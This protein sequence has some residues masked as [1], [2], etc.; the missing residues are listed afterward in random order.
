M[1]FGLVESSVYGYNFMKRLNE[2]KDFEID[3]LE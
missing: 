3:D 1:Y 2:I